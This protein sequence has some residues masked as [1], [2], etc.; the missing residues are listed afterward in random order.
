MLKVEQLTVGL[1][2]AQSSSVLTGDE[3]FAT[4]KNGIMQDYAPSEL[5]CDILMAAHHGALDFF[6]A[7]GS[8]Y[9]YEAH[10]S[11]MAPA[12]TVVSVGPNNYGHPDPTALRLYEKHSSGSRQENK[13]FKTDKQGNMK[14]TFQ[15]EGSWSL[16][17]G[18]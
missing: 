11:T 9:Y 1:D 12:M 3:D 18:Q 5:S 15:A 8:H 13:L 17:T 6:D 10:V 2:I 14:L 4:W 7:P 16:S